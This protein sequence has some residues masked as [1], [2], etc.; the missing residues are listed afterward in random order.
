MEQNDMMSLFQDS[1]V[2]KTSIS[3]KEALSER[4]KWEKRK[5]RLGVMRAD[6]TCN[7][8][9]D[10][11][12]FPTIKPYFGTPDTTL[13][14]FKT[15]MSADRHNCWVH[16]FMFD[17][18]FEQIWNPS[19]T[20]RDL[21]ALTRFRGILTPDFT[22]NPRL[23]PIQQQF[24]VFRNRAIGQL[25]QS[26]NKPVIATVGW[27]FRSSFDYC[28]AG[29]SEGGTVAI[30]TNGVLKN[31]VSLRMFKEGVFEMERRL[32]PDNIVVVGQEIPIKTKAQ[33]IWYPNTNTTLRL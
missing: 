18:C 27:S 9:L 24:N 5:A 31:I 1:E 20:D 7:L 4:D 25:M 30:S 19:Y 11:Q 15:A 10:E 13:I 28:F 33:Q 29:L 8:D 23:S 2:E 26:R 22:L 14:D 12:G 6:L 17:E 16:F 32:R 21:D 3:R